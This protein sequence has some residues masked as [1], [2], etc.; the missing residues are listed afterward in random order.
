MI[1]GLLLAI[2]VEL[3]F[4]FFG[5]QH[6]RLPLHA[7]DHVEGRFGAA[8]QGQFQDVFTDAL[9]DGFAHLVLDFKEAVSRAQ[10]ADALMRAL[11]VV[12]LHP[13]ADALARL[14]EIIEL[15]TAEEFTPDAV[16]EALHLAQGHRVMGP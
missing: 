16:P 4:A 3:E 15:G 8:A 7:P 12:M 1:G 13:E 6:D 11:V 14:F 5:P 2:D 9:L 10:T